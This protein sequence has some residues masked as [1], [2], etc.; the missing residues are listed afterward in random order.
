MPAKPEGKNPFDDLMAGALASGKDS[1]PF[2]S[3]GA[4][5]STG[6]RG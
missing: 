3:T 6:V 5:P 4:K 2:A 1:N